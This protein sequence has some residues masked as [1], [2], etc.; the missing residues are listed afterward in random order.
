ML[1]SVPM[2]I[3]QPPSMDHLHHLLSLAL[4]H[5]LPEIRGVKRHASSIF[6][7]MSMTR[8]KRQAF[9]QTLTD[10]IDAMAKFKPI[11]ACNADLA[12]FQVFETLQKPA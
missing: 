5:L 10:G 4:F 11:D 8:V 3:Q 1:K 12:I 9:K 2:G 7:M 6:M